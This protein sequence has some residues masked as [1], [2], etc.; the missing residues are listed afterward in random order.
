[1]VRSLVRHPSTARFLATK[2]VRHFVADD[3]PQRAV[4][5]VADVFTPSGGDL[6]EV[7]R[8]VVG[9]PEAW[10]PSHRKIRTPQDWAVAALRALGVREVPEPL[11]A[12][13]N[14][15]RQPLWAPP[16][17]K[18]WGD[19]VREW[20]DPDSLMNRAELA[21]S[22]ARRARDVRPEALVAALD[23]AASDPIYTL[24]AD[25]SIPPPERVALV[26]AGPAFQWR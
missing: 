13:L 16:S 3:P 19:T 23:V 4:D 17:P 5:T 11:P 18:G 15:L 12:L 21:R 6:R 26:L 25:D 9:L 22:L 1:M 7:A 10:D 14:Q 20:A 2:L 24:V 8:A